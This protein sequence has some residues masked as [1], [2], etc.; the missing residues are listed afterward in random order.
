M[1]DNVEPDGD[2]APAAPEFHGSHSNGQQPKRVCSKTRREIEH[3][4]SEAK[5]RIKSTLSKHA[6]EATPEQSVNKP[7]RLRFFGSIF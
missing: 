2:E 5:K 7:A 3:S 4:A 6:A 1:I